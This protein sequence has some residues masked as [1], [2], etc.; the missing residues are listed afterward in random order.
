MPLRYRNSVVCIGKCR[1][2]VEYENIV[3]STEAEDLIVFM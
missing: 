1:V 2:E 3:P